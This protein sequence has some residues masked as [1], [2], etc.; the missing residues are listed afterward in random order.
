MLDTVL[1]FPS[2]QLRIYTNVCGVSDNG[3]HHANL[4][5]FELARNPEYLLNGLVSN[6]IFARSVQRG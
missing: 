6:Q 5:D 1:P 3:E 4:S 2:Q